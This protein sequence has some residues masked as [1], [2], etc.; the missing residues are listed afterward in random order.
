MRRSHVHGHAARAADRGAHPQR[1]AGGRVF[2]RSFSSSGIDLPEDF[3]SLIEEVTLEAAGYRCRRGRSCRCSSRQFTIVFDPVTHGTHR[4]STS[5]ASRPRERQSLTVVYDKV[6]AP[7]RHRW[8]CGRAAAPADRESHR[9]A[10]AA[11]G[12]GSQATSSTTCSGGASRRWTREA[13]A[14]NQAFRD[15]YR[16]DTLDVN[17]RLKITASP[18]FHHLKGSTALRPRRRPR[19]LRPRARAFPRCCTRSSRSESAR[20]GQDHRRSR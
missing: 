6:A 16:T 3:E 13:P 11:V 17:Q 14:R 7:D 20:R 1:A 18:S 9:P 15:L 10:R 19:R 12:A 8:R 2:R 4:S 5:R